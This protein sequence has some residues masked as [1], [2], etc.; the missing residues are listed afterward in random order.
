MMMINKHPM[1][2]GFHVLNLIL[3][4]WTPGSP[5]QLIVPGLDHVVHVKPGD[6][7]IGYL[8]YV[9]RYS[10]VD[11]C[12]DKYRLSGAQHSVVPD[13]ITD[14]INK[15]STLLPNI[16]LGFV[17]FDDCQKDLTALARSVYFV[18]SEDEKDKLQKRHHYVVGVVGPNYSRQSVMISG[19]LGLFQIPV[20]STL[21][22]SDDLSD[23][24]RFP[25]FMRLVPPDKLQTIALVKIIEYFGWSYVSL[26]YS[27]GSYGENAAKNIDR[28][29][30][31]SDMCLAVSQQISSYFTE[32]DLKNVINRISAHKHAPVV[33]LFLESI[34]LRR[35]FTHL[36]N[37]N[38]TSQ[39]L[40]L[41]SDTLPSVRG[42]DIEDVAIGSVL[43]T[44]R[45][46]DVPGFSEYI[47]TLSWRNSTNPWLPLIFQ[48]AYDCTWNTKTSNG[49]TSKPSCDNWDTLEE[50]V[51][52]NWVNP[53]RHVDGFVVYAKAIHALI[54]D[55]CPELFTLD[56]PRN[57]SH[58]IRG[59]V[60]LDYM[61][62]LSYEGY[63][64]HI[65]FDSNGDMMGQYSV[66]QVRR[67]KDEIQFHKYV[68]GNWDVLTNSFV[69]NT[70]VLNWP[71]GGV[72]NL[73]RMEVES[74]CSRP[75][76]IGH[77]YQNK[78][79]SCCWECV[80]CRDNEITVNNLTD[81]EPCPDFTWPDNDTKST[82]ED[83][84]LHFLHHS[85]AIGICILCLASLGVIKS[86]CIIVVYVVKRNDRLLKATSRELSIVILVG[87]IFACLG[88][89][90]FVMHPDRVRCILRQ[91]SFHLIVCI[92]YSPLLVKTFR[93]YRIF[94]ESQKGM[95]K[96]ICV[97]NRTQLL[98][99]ILII[100]SQ[101]KCYISNII[102][103]IIQK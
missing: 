24:A 18:P 62:N 42:L 93:V 63:S 5:G 71:D 100:T 56:T 53:G 44:H 99:T 39:F 74:I 25:Y 4:L 61:K 59:H 20:L 26:L 79:V 85:H 73:A 70:S 40:F 75:C 3:L 45:F 51:G 89:A 23:K 48:S 47:R 54:S 95:T 10:S 103:H 8:S 88:S 1:I 64:G 49:N 36:K 90:L 83:I 97:S 91:A 94:T 60:L 30:R 82:C 41:A 31:T 21:A 7:N 78:E 101:V 35:L 9:H 32:E 52:V 33:I 81:C 65:S 50:A 38:M 76:D 22:T 29:A 80:R 14:L 98:M 2:G 15:D 84:P 68:I 67:D 87:C 58:C 92:M 86:S 13:F 28:L 16:T 43:V 19:F 27:E 66:K 46:M 72:R 17:A 77:Y 57:F 34:D 69:V 12:S 55:H 96:L 37:N 6:I 11:F 102:I